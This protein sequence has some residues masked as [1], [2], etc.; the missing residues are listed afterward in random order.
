MGSWDRVRS[1]FTLQKLVEYIASAVVALL[2]LAFL[3][4][5][6]SLPPLGWVLVGVAMFLAVL[7]VA[8]WLRHRRQQGQPADRHERLW[9]PGPGDPSSLNDAELCSEAER[10]AKELRRF[11]EQHSMALPP[12]EWIRIPGDPEK[13]KQFEQWREADA[14]QTYETT[15]QRRAAAVY[16]ELVRRRGYE[17]P[18]MQNRYNNIH[19]AGEIDTVAGALQ[20]M[21]NP[22]PRRRE[23]D[24]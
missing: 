8:L 22:E 24:G 3:T 11:R 2:L 15:F 20:D 9:G 6:V 17:H 10:L 13:L 16:E 14:I 5:L 19:M 23:V 21:A 12:L 18:M 4:G 7:A 1:A